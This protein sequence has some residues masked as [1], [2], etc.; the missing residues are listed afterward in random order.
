MSRVMKNDHQVIDRIVGIG[1]GIM[2]F[3]KPCRKGMKVSGVNV[4]ETPHLLTISSSSSLYASG[5]C[6]LLLV[7]YGSW[8]QVRSGTR[9]RVSV[10]SCWFCG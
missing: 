8:E 7:K 5:R 1:I 4:G 10:S 3:V 6:I 2:D 9:I